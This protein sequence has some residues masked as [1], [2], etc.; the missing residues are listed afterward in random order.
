M[1]DDLTKHFIEQLD[2]LIEQYDRMR[3][4]SKRDDLSDIELQNAQTLI[5]RATA[6]IERTCGSRS[7]YCEQAAEVLAHPTH[8]P[9]D[10]MTIVVGIA[11]ALRL[12]LDAGY[13]ASFEELVHGTLF[14]DYLE[15][16]TH[17]L[18]KKYKDPAAVI[19][20]VTLEG[21]LRQLCAKYGIDLEVSTA[22]GVRR[23]SADGMNAELV[24]AG[25]YDKLDQKS[26][27]AWL[28]LRNKAAHA[29]W[30]KFTKEQVDPFV[31]WL[32]DFIRRVPA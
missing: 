18:E 16:A 27:T 10:K 3:E 30:D 20:G 21:H 13:L 8:H 11:R 31:A 4:Q 26:V 15:I 9:Y 6:A 28:D 24:R 17:L 22:K 1:P 23:R 12:D 19:A 2:V 29:E 14:A 7:T 32:R 5:T 25:A